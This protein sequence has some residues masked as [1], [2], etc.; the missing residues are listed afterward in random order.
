MRLFHGLRLRATRIYLKIRY[1]DLIILGKDFRVRKR[2]S[3]L[4]DG[5]CLTIGDN[6][7]FNNDCSIAVM[8]NVTIGNDTIFGENVRI[9]D[10]NHSFHNDKGLIRLQE[11]SVGG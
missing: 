5:G 6:V 7:F 3:C 11:L 9:F 4:I 2:F 1:G 10:H 8:N